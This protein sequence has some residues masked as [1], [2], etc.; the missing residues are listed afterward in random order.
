[1]IPRPHVRRDHDGRRRRRA[2]TPGVGRL[3]QILVL[4]ALFAFA[5][6]SGSARA[7]SGAVAPN[8]TNMVDCNGWSPT[9]QSVKP[10]MRGLCTDFFISEHGE[11]YRGSD[12]GH[13]VGHDEPSVKFISSTPSSGNT[14]TYFMRLGVDPKKKPTA[15]G[16]TT[17]YAELSP[18]PWFGLP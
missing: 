3:G 12:N 17:D 9:Y 5:L 2:M 11:S 4:A 1:M 18:A 15:D 7:V 14:M 6:T 10:T 16:T 8:P 13:Y